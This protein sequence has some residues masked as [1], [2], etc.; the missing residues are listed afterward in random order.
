MDSRAASVDQRGAG[1]ALESVGRTITTAM[2]GIKALADHLDS[3]PTFSQNLVAAIKL[4]GDSSGRIVVSGVGKSGHIGRKIAATI[5]STGTSAY[6]VHPTEASHGDLGNITSQD[7][8]ILLSWSGETAELANILTY[9]RRFQVPIVSIS[10]NRDSVLARNSDAPIVL[11]KV[12]EACP[13]GLAPTTSTV[14]QLIV[15]DALA[16]ALLQRRGFSAEDF[17]AFHPG[18]KLGAQL[19]RVRELAH[20]D[21]RVPLLSVGRPM[22]EA[23]IEMSAKG[24]G[25]VGIVDEDGKLA[26]IITDGDLRRHMSD[27]LLSKPVEEI[28]SLE[29]RVIDGDV[30]AG[31]A[32]KGMQQDRIT[33]LF[34]V[35]RNQRAYG[36]LHIHDL[37]RAGVI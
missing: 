37:I 7:V 6:F 13:H 33:V 1:A 22:S 3:D 26:G 15:G 21:G 9:A 12:R 25:V 27:D 28:M 10:S 19:R 8:L 17:K 11:P 32:I 24:F 31:T 34:M 2:E 30:L 29:P 18:G 16:I 20:T 5:A 4:I 23:V 14:L 36:I 35:D